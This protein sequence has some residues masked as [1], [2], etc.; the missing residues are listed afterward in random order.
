M[1][2]EWGYLLCMHLVFAFIA[3]VRIFFSD[4]TLVKTFQEEIRKAKNHFTIN[5]NK[6]EH[7]TWN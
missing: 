6:T 4:E 1:R 7:S 5:L 2:K 3:Q